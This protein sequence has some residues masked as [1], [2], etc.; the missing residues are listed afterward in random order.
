MMS[1]FPSGIVQLLGVL[2]KQWLEI[3]KDIAK[4]TISPHL[5]L[6]LG[7]RDQLKERLKPDPLRAKE[8]EQELSKGMKGI[9]QRIWPK[10]SNV[11]CVIGGSFG[12]YLDRLQ[13]Y[14]GDLPIFSAMYGATEALIG[15]A[16]DVNAVSYVVTP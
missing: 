12:I 2:E 7:V 8:L 1:P 9:A 4:G 13:Y 3:L 11:S 10:M 5:T 14:I 15:M 16:I 6:D